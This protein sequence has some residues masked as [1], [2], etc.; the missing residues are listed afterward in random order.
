MCG[1]SV[2][3]FLIPRGGVVIRMKGGVI[4]FRSGLGLGNSLGFCA[5]PRLQVCKF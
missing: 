1:I 2:F 3:V 4:L 5:G